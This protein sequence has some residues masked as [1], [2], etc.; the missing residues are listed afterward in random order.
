MHTILYLNMPLHMHAHMHTCIPMQVFA[1]MAARMHIYY[2]HRNKHTCTAA[3]VGVYK[4]TYIHTYVHTYACMHTYMHAYA[5][6]DTYIR[7][8]ICLHADIHACIHRDRYIHA[9]MHAYLRRHAH[10]IVLLVHLVSKTSL[11]S[12]QHITFVHTC[13]HMLDTYSHTCIHL[14]M[15]VRIHTLMFHVG[16]SPKKRPLK[17]L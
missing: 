6:T 16:W 15:H 12:L 5:E 2:I 4:D 11:Q 7:T 8:Y 3:Y 13:K 10:S 17:F 9:C 14:N 1:N